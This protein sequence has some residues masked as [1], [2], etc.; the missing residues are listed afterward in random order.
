MVGDNV[1]ELAVLARALI[2]TQEKIS[3]ICFP[4]PTFSE[5]VGEAI[6]NAFEKK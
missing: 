4:H 3:D 6:E 1:N 5:V 2:G